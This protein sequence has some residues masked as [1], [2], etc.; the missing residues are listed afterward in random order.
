MTE[1]QVSLDSY[2][3]I[4][5]AKKARKCLTISLLPDSLVALKNTSTG[6]KN[7]L[8]IKRK[9]LTLVKPV[10]LLEATKSY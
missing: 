5:T 2:K 7:K 3:R 10:L 1:F 8:S 9:A 4:V 6:S